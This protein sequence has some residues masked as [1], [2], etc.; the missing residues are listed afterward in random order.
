M[1]EKDFEFLL[2]NSA[3]EEVFVN[4]LV[5]NETIWLT[6]K[7]MVE[8]FGCSTDNISLHLKNIFADGELEENRTAE[9][10]S[11]VQ[12]EGTR[13][14]KR[15]QKFYNLDAI[16]GQT[17]AEIIYTHADSEKDNMGLTIWK[18]APDVRV[19]KSDVTV[20]KNYLD[21]KQI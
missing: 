20:A 6:Q 9:E 14:V 13:Q 2:Y 16:T 15:K 12:T 18:N 17:G 1:D 7:A 10:T 8:L 4:A 19:L 21:E 3:D 11:I 5:K